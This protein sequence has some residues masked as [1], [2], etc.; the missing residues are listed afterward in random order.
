MLPQTHACS[1]KHIHMDFGCGW[2]AGMLGWAVRVQHLRLGQMMGQQHTHS[3]THTYMHTH[4]HT[5]T[6][7]P[8]YALTYTRTVQKLFFSTKEIFIVSQINSLHMIQPTESSQTIRLWQQCTIHTCIIY[9][10]TFTELLSTPHP[11]S[12]PAHQKNHE[13]ILFFRDPVLASMLFK[14]LSFR[15]SGV[16]AF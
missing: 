7:T 15:D 2:G 13:R 3:L 14:V 8:T 6:M 12:T 4:T 1:F 5:H 16:K 10:C 9:W 11:P